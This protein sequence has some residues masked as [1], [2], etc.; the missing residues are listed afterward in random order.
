MGGCALEVLEHSTTAIASRNFPQSVP[1]I[2]L[3]REYEGD[4]AA[5]HLVR[6]SLFAS[7]FVPLGLITMVLYVSHK[8]SGAGV[9][10]VFISLIVTIWV[11]A[12][13]PYM[14]K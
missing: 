13:I 14:H 8:T 5:I 1:V 11:Q 9:E 10:I 6:I 3:L 4:S 12:F 2:D 7:L